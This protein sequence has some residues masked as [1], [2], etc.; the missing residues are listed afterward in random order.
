QGAASYT[1]RTLEEIAS[2]FGG[3]TTLGRSTFP[4]VSR[5]NQPQH[6]RPDDEAGRC[7]PARHS[8]TTS[9]RP[10]PGGGSKP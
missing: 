9:T 2:L 8:N 1:T 5:L 4:F 10:R 7:A 3:G 6:Q